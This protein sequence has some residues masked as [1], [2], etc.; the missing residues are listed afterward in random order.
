MVEMGVI[1]RSDGEVEASHDTAF[2]VVGEHR[3]RVPLAGGVD[4]Y[5]PDAATIER[6]ARDLTLL[7]TADLDRAARAKLRE[8]M[9]TLI[10][11]LDE[12]DRREQDVPLR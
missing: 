3:R 12:L 6:A 11:R 2:V 9:S 5:R 7:G 10:G 4:A 1:A 8:A